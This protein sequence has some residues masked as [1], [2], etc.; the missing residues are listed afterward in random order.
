[1]K[2]SF[3]GTFDVPR[4]ELEEKLK[5]G[6]F[7]VINFSGKT[8]VL[9]VGEKTASSSKII[10]A[11]NLG[12][13][14]LREIDSQKILSL[15]CGDDTSYC[16]CNDREY[17]AE[18]AFAQVV[19]VYNDFCDYNRDAGEWFAQDALGWLENFDKQNFVEAIKIVV[20]PS[21]EAKFWKAVKRLMVLDIVNEEH[22]DWNGVTITPAQLAIS[23]EDFKKRLL[24]LEFIDDGE[25]FLE[26]LDKEAV[27]KLL[28]LTDEEG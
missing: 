21:D 9:L 12:I 20:N 8:E 6:G 5:E 10:K 13:K 4:K 7:D 23:D 24:K 2:I 28:K 1:M 17:V 15:L 25:E 18:V 22:C 11:E 14:V 3:T 26:E 19:D 16:R 27:I